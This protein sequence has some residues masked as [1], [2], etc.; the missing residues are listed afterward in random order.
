M[1]PDPAAPASLEVTVSG[2][3]G[4]PPGHGPLI[5][6]HLKIREGKIQEASYET[7]PWPG[8]HACGKGLCEIIAG[9]HIEEARSLGHDHLVEKVGPCPPSAG[10]ATGWQ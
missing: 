6:L 3:G 1:G 8:Y 10:I 4:N 2:Y 5:T 9:K 7:Y